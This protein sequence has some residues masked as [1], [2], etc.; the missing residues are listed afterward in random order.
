[1]SS[2]SLKRALVLIDT[3]F[4]NDNILLTAKVYFLGGFCQ[5]SV[6]KRSGHCHI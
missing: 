4:F 6:V 2:S 5:T 1:M 3:L